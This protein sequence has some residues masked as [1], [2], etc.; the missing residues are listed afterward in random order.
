MK[1]AN[2]RWA[3]PG[4]IRVSIGRPVQFRE[5]DSAEE[6]A[7]DLE[8]RV[9]ELGADGKTKNG[10]KRQPSGAAGE[11]CPRCGAENKN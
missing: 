3:R 11:R 6:I 4:A 5:T 9:A 8:Q 7:R 10:K 1:R 2:K